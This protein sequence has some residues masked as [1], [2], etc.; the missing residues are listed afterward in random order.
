M[1]TSFI[2]KPNITLYHYTASRVRTQTKIGAQTI[3]VDIFT[4]HQ[5]EYF[6][7]DANDIRLMKQILDRAIKKEETLISLM[8]GSG[9]EVLVPKGIF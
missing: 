1:T 9:V 8:N 7:L 4:K 6:A 2:Y 3:H 5:A